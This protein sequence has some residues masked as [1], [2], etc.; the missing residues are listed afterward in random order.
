LP[1]STFSIHKT[2]TPNIDQVAVSNAI[3]ATLKWFNSIV[4][5]I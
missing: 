3:F 1:T 4:H 2:Q 5:I